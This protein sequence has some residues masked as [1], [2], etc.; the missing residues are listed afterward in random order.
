MFTVNINSKGTNSCYEQF[1]EEF[2]EICNQHKNEGRALVFA[3]IVY[4]FENAHISQM[5]N[6]SDYWI[7]LNAVSGNYLTVFSL[8]YKPEDMKEKLME[9]MRQKMDGA[10]KNLHFIP[11][12]QNPSLDSNNLIKKYFGNDITINYPSVLFFQ[13]NGEKV[14]DY[15]L[16][17]L[18]QERL[19]DSFI[20]LK[21][22]IRSAANALTEVNREQ[23]DEK[24]V[25]NLVDQTVSGIRQ[26]IQIKKGIKIISSITELATTVTGLN[27]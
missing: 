26:A 17:E 7:S 6:N 10:I 2:L 16:I 25:F 22:Y 14:T 8:H 4:D 13:T 1:E 15:R 9:M 19:E 20:E 12:N 27:Q 23:Y 21:K 3:F 5:L 11:A 18:D 24:T